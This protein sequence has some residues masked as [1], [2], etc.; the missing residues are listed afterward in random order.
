MAKTKQNNLTMGKVKKSNIK[1]FKKK[2]ITN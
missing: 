2:Q 1:R